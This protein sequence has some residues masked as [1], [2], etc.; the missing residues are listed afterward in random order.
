MPTEITFFNEFDSKT[1]V[2]SI[3][4]LNIIKSII[5]LEKMDCKSVAIILVTDEKL[6]NMHEEYLDDPEQ[7]DVITFNLGDEQIEAEIYI[8]VDRA[9]DQSKQF[10]VTLENELKRLLVHGLLHLAGYDD[11]S[12]A[13]IEIMR[14]RESYYLTNN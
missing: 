5:S 11:H 7:T 9:I 2:E 14:E 10:N 8:S 13:E 1:S 3:D 6:R 4:N 12:S